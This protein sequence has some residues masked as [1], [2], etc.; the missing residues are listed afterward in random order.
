M[1]VAIWI[2]F[3]AVQMVGYAAPDSLD[4]LIVQWSN[5]DASM[6]KSGLFAVIQMPS[7]A[8]IVEVAQQALQK[9]DQLAA[10]NPTVV[11]VCH[12]RI[13]H[14]EEAHPD[15]YPGFDPNYTA[16]L[17]RTPLGE[18]IVILQFLPVEDIR[19]QP[20]YWWNRV[21]N[22]RQVFNPQGGANGRQPFSSETNRTPAAAA[23]RRSP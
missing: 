8:P 1:K 6:F 5:E 11:R 18:R 20:G 2:A 19:D 16:V 12:V 21:Y 17:L 22:P 9:N 23:S 13:S 4:R 14:G 3:L 15:W 10:T 7:N